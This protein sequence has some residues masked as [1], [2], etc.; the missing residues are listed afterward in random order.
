MNDRNSPQGPYPISTDREA[1]VELASR[2]I[3][4]PS[5]TPED[6][7]AQAVLMDR[8][9]AVGFSITPIVDGESTAF[10]AELFTEGTPM[11]V[12]AGH[13]DVVPPGDLSQWTS[14][15]FTPTVRDGNLFGRGAADM[16]GNVASFIVAIEEFVRE[17][18]KPLQI[19]LGVV[20]SG[21]EE[22]PPNIGTS[23]VM[24]HLQSIG[25]KIDFCLNAE[26]TSVRTLGDIVK[27]GR[28]GACNAFIRIQGKQGHSAYPEL[29]KTPVHL[30][31]M[32][33]QE[34]ATYDWDRD[35]PGLEP[36]TSLQFTW[37]KTGTTSHNVIPGVLDLCCNIRY[38]LR[39]AKETMQR[40]I[41]DILRRH[42]L[43]F[44][45]EWNFFALPF[46][47]ADGRLLAVTRQAIKEIAGVDTV[48]S[49]GGG[50]S[51]ARFIAPFCAEV[52]ELGLVGSSIHAINEHASIADMVTLK[53]I[54]KRILVELNNS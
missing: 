2:L 15:P 4:C 3:S 9:A 47:A 25:R 50:T 34:I 22:G 40:V 46:Q 28:R 6:G 35:F 1:T 31:L 43:D 49:S 23:N 36:K 44:S 37:V 48:C 21:D 13:T 19:S 14:D 8:L 30:S 17:S 42:S 39:L 24:K 41:E 52:L 29:A 27:N 33:L 26:P 18:A 10:W 20:I 38:P 12:F 51:D 11:V 53:N 54:F 7:G 45:I 32:A 5:I 16:K